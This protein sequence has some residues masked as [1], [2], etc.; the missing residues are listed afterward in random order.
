MTLSALTNS[1]NSMSSSNSINSTHKPH[2]P[3]PCPVS[4][5]DLSN[6]PPGANLPPGGEQPVAMHEECGDCGG[7][8]IVNATDYTGGVKQEGR[9]KCISCGSRNIIKVPAGQ[10]ASLKGPLPPPPAATNIAARKPLMEEP[11]EKQQKHTCKIEG[12]DK[13]VMADGM[14][15]KHFKEEH[16]ISYPDFRRRHK[17]GE[18]KGEIFANPGKPADGLTSGKDAIKAAHPETKRSPVVNIVA[19]DVGLYVSFIRCKHLGEKLDR[20]AV[21]EFRTPEGQILALI[22]DAEEVSI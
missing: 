19:T 11:M 20:L 4:P 5:A 22:R 9:R 14:C 2:G 17:A 18:T 16:G 8:T 10:H 21:S 15:S 13:V 1:S 7:H 3:G 6:T 12:C